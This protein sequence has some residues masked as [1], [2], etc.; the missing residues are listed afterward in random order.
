MFAIQKFGPRITATIPRNCRPLHKDILKLAVESFGFIVPHKGKMTGPEF[1]AT[2][3][4]HCS[5]S[6]AAAVA[7][8]VSQY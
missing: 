1:A 8:I 4:R 6:K 2:I 3:K 7:E 5:D